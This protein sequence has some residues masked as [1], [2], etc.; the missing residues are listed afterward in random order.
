MDTLALVLNARR[1]V[2]IAINSVPKD[3]TLSMR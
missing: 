3:N 1:I 2:I